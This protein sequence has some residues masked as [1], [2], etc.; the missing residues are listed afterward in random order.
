MQ[1][2]IMVGQVA[3]A[4]VLLIGAALLSRSFLAMMHADRGYDLSNLL[5][6]RVL[7]PDFLF[8]PD[9][10]VAVLDETLSRGKTLPGVTRIGFADV[11]PLS[12]GE[13]MTGFT[14]PSKRPPVGAEIR[15]NAVRR[16]VSQDYFRVLGISAVEGRVFATTDT[17]NSP[18]VV[19]VNRMF[20]SK[21]LSDRPVGDKLVNFFRDDGFEYE[22]IGVIPDVMQMGLRDSIQPEIYSLN[23]QMPANVLGS[24]QNYLVRVQGDPRALIDPFRGILQEQDPAIMID[25]VMTMEDRL[26]TSLAKPRLYAVLLGTFASSALL[27]AGV[28][29]FGVLSYNVAQR[30]REFAVRNVMGATPMNL[31]SLVFADGLTLTAG[32]VALGVSL[33]FVFVRYLRTLLYGVSAHDFV[34]ISIVCLAT[35][36]IALVACIVPALRAGRVDPITWL[37]E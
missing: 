5:S 35:V 25:S 3:M 10:R 28:G 34:S 12:S 9:R 6:I 37:K 20:A 24:T 19:I 27:I 18:K 2:I 31:L 29:L 22:V 7:M 4:S 30:A 11:L 8:K 17:G 13:T 33:S 32:G 14:M 16:V 36:A 23:L 26:S 21:F 1:V 15:V